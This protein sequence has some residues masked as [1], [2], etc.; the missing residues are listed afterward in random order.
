MIINTYMGA[1][2]PPKLNS[3]GLETSR[4]ADDFKLI[5]RGTSVYM[6]LIHTCE[7]NGTN[8]FDYLTELERHAEDLVRNPA[9]WMPWNYRSRIA[10]S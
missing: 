1:F 3:I 4:L 5:F 9:E 7:L 6:S 2:V 8:P 10:E